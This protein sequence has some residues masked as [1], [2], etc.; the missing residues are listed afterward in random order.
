MRVTCPQMACALAQHTRWRGTR[1]EHQQ[2][3][4]GPVGR[5]CASQ[6]AIGALYLLRS[7]AMTVCQFSAESSVTLF[8][9]AAALTQSE[10]ANSKW[11]GAGTGL[12]IVASSFPHF[13]QTTPV[14]KDIPATPLRPLK[15][16]FY[17]S[18]R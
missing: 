5:I 1:I 12:I 16:P 3:H 18:A 13:T 2:R 4:C 10:Q 8:A 15:R 6:N 7:S 17:H 11:R 14:G 9:S